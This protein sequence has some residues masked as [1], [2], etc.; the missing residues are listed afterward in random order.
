MSTYIVTVYPDSLV[1]VSVGTE[2]GLDE[3]TIVVRVEDGQSR[4]NTSVIFDTREK[5]ERFYTALGAV[6]GGERVAGDVYPWE[7][8]PGVNRE[9]AT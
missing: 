3:R 2:R 9:A 8:R 5:V 4:E 6:L 7:V 1:R